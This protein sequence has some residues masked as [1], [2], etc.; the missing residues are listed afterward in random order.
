M[1]ATTSPHLTDTPAPSV[2]RR[3]LG[4][5]LTLFLALS[6]T[7]VGAEMGAERGVWPLIGAA[8]GLLLLTAA[9]LN[10]PLL[11]N[12]LGLLLRRLLGERGARVAFGCIA[13]VFAL[14][15]GLGAITP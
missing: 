11:W 14:S 7:S 13:I 2:G 9:L 6:V 4:V 8:G 3:V 1:T 10:W 12:P 15:A 5:L